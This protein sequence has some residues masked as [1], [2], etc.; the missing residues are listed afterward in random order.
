MKAYL[1]DRIHNVA[2]IGSGGTGKTSLCEALLF[3]ANAI[4]RLGKVDDGNSTGD[5][6]PE[7]IKRKIS[8]HSAL[9]PLEWE[10]HKVNLID[11]PGF[12]DFVGEGIAALGVVE[13]AIVVIDAVAGVG[14][15]V[16]ALWQEASRLNLP[17]VIV[18][19]KLDKNQADFN[20]Q[21]EQVRAR[22]GK[23][24]V[25]VQLPLGQEANFKGSYNLL[26]PDG[27]PAEIKEDYERYR[28]MLIEATAEVDE[29]ILNEY[30]DNK[31][32]TEEEIIHAIKRGIEQNKVTPILC[33]SATKEIGI[34]ELLD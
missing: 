16:E 9:L 26:K 34:K 7:E 15:G 11:T 23:Q 20:G 19:N 18:I 3:K 17:K 25:P 2:V 28:E 24:A 13:G 27:V 1:A 30:L 21:V 4:A 22:F 33:A 10:D 5:Y 32:I 31:P 8:I 14:V 6:D 12:I 29:T